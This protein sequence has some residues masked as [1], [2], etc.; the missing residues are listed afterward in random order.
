MDPV[1]GEDDEFHDL[2][3]VGLEV[4]DRGGQVLGAVSEVMHLP[5]QDLLAVAR[6]DG[7]ELLVPFVTE[8]VPVVDMPAG[9]LLV[10]LPERSG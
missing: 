1:V 4:R 2:V 5:G 9:F 3:L 7:P 10:E 6:S 8:F